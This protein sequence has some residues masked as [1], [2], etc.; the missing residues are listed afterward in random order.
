MELKG[1]LRL[2]H[3]VSRK[4]V[5]RPMCVLACTSHRRPTGS[6][7]RLRTIYYGECKDDSLPLKS[8]RSGVG[9]GPSLSRL[10]TR[11]AQE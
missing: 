7:C 1:L 2:E 11:E 9:V 4:C 5:A 6:Y 3:T 8:V 10:P